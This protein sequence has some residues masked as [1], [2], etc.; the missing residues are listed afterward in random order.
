MDYATRD[1][2]LKNGVSTWNVNRNGDVVIDK[3]I[4]HQ[5]TTNGA[6]DTTFRDIQAVYQVIYALKK[7]RADLAYEHSNKAL[8]AGKPIEP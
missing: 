4:T 1:A 3:I 5:Q 2:M 6:P 8:G 7:F